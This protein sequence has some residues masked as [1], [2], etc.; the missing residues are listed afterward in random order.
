LISGSETEIVPTVAST[1]TDTHRKRPWLVWIILLFDVVGL[2]LIL[3][4]LAAIYSGRVPLNAAQR[5]YYANL[6]IFDHLATLALGTINL[7]ASISLFRLRASAVPL[8]G[9]ALVLNFAL[10]IRAAL[11]SNWLESLGRDGRVGA[12]LGLIIALA[13]LLYALRLRHKGILL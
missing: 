11:T 7:I 8:F 3:L 5:T 1:I 13:V 4:G 6:G 2:L 10:S 12:S 9:V